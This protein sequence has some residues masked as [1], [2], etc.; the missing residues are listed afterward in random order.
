MYVRVRVCVWMC[1]GTD[2]TAK[3]VAQFRNPFLTY[4]EVIRRS[5]NFIGEKKRLIRKEVELKNIERNVI[6]EE[7]K[8]PK[9]Y[10]IINTATKTTKRQKNV[11]YN[12]KQ[13]FG[14]GEPNERF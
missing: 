1:S 8:Q 2:E 9:Y 6:E 7:D 14:S 11:T 12:S 10:N 3:F 13:K 5:N 4:G